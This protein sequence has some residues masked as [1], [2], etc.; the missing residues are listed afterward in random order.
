MEENKELLEVA[1]EIAKPVYDDLVHPIAEPTGRVLSLV[2]RAIR[3]ALSPLE[4]WIM[5]KEYNIEATRKILEEKLANTPEELIDTPEPYIAVPALQ[6]ISYC[7]DNEVLRDMYANLLAT[8]MKKDTRD[9]AHPS[10]ADIISQLSP[11]E[12]KVLSFFKF[13]PAAPTVTVK[14]KKADFS[15]IIIYNHFSAL[16]EIVACDFPYE[17]NKYFDNLSRLGLIEKTNQEYLAKE[18]FYPPLIEH[19]FVKGLEKER[20][21]YKDTTETEYKKGKVSVTDYGKA[22]CECCISLPITLKKLDEYNMIDIK[23]PG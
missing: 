20:A 16:G 10:F 3:I 21:K 1:K 7:M 15:E 18:S 22:F 14:F 17:I 5:L 8:S 13:A 2:P 9:K 4:K 12:A 23:L 19:P 6:R 11:D